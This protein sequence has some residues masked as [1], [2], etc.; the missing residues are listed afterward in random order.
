M[1]FVWIN[2]CLDML[3]S[4]VI[5]IRYLMNLNFVKKYRYDVKIC[6]KNL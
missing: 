4:Y 3:V 5:I 6:D 1:I 2:F